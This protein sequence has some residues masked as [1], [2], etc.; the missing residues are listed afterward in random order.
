MKPVRIVPV[1][2][3]GPAIQARWD[4]E[5]LSY[6]GGVGGWQTHDRPGRPAAAEWGQR[7]LYEVGFDWLFDGLAAGVSV[8]ADVVALERLAQPAGSR[9]RPA[10]VR[11]DADWHLRGLRWHI[12]GLDWHGDP[13]PVRDEQTGDRLRQQVRVQL[14]EHIAVDVVPRPRPASARSGPTRQPSARS[15]SM[16]TVQDG[17]T[18]W[19]LAAEHLGDGQRFSEIADLNDI[20]NPDLIAVGDEL[21]LPPR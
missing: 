20:D 12:T 4:P 13:L 16:I 10:V 11:V 15:A 19:A 14:Q 21:R 8:E 5:T 6:S 18:L 3:R 1:D 2:P 17:D 9:D 7:P